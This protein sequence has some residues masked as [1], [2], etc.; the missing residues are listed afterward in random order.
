MDTAPASSNGS[1]GRARWSL[2]LLGGFE[3]R[4]LLDSERVASLGKR[5][6][7][8]L[9][10]LALSPN[11]RQPR[12]KL[13][14][15]LWGDTTDEAA[16][17]SLRTSVWNLRRVL[18]DAEHRV[19]ASEGEDI[20]LDVAAFDVDALAFRRLASQSGRVE[21]EEAANLYVDEFLDGLG[22]ENEDF[23]SWRREETARCRDQAIDVLSRL[24][25]LLAECGETERAIE[26][27]TR[28]LRL[29]P[30]HE[31]AARRLMRLYRESGR[32]GAAVQLY[33][34]LAGALRTELDAQPEAETRLIF[35]EVSRSG[36]EQPRAPLVDEP[37]AIDAAP[38]YGPSLVVLPFANLSGGGDHEFFADGITED[39]TT[40]LSRFRHLFVISRYSSFT[41][42]AKTIDARTVARELRVQYVVEG[43][44]RRVGDRVRITVQLIDSHAGRHIWA[45]HYDR[46]LNDI[47]A[48][49]DEIT[50]AIVATVPGRLD[51]A[52]RE[53]VCRKA[54]ENMT[55]YECVLEAMAL[56]HRATRADNEAALRVL[57][58]AI[59]LD[60]TYARAHAWKAC[61]LGQA[62][63]QRFC[64]DREVTAKE[65]DN[66]L[67]L[68]MQLDN[69]NCDVHRIIAAVHLTN[70]RHEK[71]LYHQQR[72][73]HLNP[74]DDLVVVQQGE[75]LTWLG[76]CEDGILWIE[77]AM[78]LNPYHPE[79]FWNHLG[80][81]YFVARRYREAI[82]AF[83]HIASPDQFHHAFLAA[84]FAQLGEGSSAKRHAADVLKRDPH[85]CIDT[86]LQTQ[87][88]KRAE[89]NEHHRDALLKSGL[90]V[91]FAEGFPRGST[92]QRK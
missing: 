89:D 73:L 40:E 4:G 20:V 47:F 31:A 33:R 2:R 81:A 86:Y 24:T 80:R 50:T 46:Q 22:I 67:Q 60:P 68:A 57:D 36:K 54:P 92:E 30:L 18:G 55:A 66:E 3:V 71:A 83:R 77:K 84:C 25:T 58:R 90:P 41:Y 52:A 48:L 74:N 13:A 38:T 49:Q 27:G 6:C 79:R 69:N 8:L 44:V 39:I 14:T 62:W 64:A 35:A 7:A 29:E 5:E 82:S 12:R 70:S 15:L 1:E 51:A 53:S 11:C 16:L 42:K 78:L 19:V 56:H 59:A 34:A 45:E 26:A 37:A 61:V 28:I 65:L 76:Q 63:I 10:Y 91:I 75:M 32:R 72:A 21:L 9:A 87:P 85:F 43:S 17:N 23:E 88:Y